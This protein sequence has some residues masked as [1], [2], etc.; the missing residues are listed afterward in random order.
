MKEGNTSTKT[1]KKQ[2]KNNDSTNKLSYVEQKE[3]K[4]LEKDIQKLE[5][6]KETFQQ[7]FVDPTLSG[8]EINDLSVSLKEIIDRIDQKTERWFELSAL[9]E[10]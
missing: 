6:E 1:Q 4:Q 9:L 5:L 3:Y 8:E 10:D 2:W 7:K